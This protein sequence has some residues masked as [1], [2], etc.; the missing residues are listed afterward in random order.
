[1]ST[2]HEIQQF[3]AAPRDQVVVSTE[4]DQVN[5]NPG[6]DRSAVIAIKDLRIEYKSRELGNQTKVA[7]NDLTLSVKAGEVFG[8]LGPNGAGKTSTM[9][10]LLGFVVAARASASIF[11]V[12]VEDAIAR[13]RLGYLPEM[14]YYYKF[15]TAEE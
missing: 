8:F 2:I 6:T 4:C 1:M 7:V 14:T 15:L 10:V 12:N 3:T 9:N 11:G 13:Q 5:G